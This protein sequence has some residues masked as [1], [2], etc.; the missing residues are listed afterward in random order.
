MLASASYAT[1]KGLNRPFARPTAQSRRMGHKLSMGLTPA[2]VAR[3]EG[4]PAAEVESLLTDPDFASLAEG[5]RALHAMSEEEQ[6]RILTQLARHLLMEATALGDVRVATY[7]LLQ[8]RMGK[9]PART[10]A[11]GVIAAAKREPRPAPL[12]ALRTASASP[13]PAR[14]SDDPD[15]RAI[16]RVEDRLCGELAHEHAVVHAAVAADE[17]AADDAAEAAAESGADDPDPED[18]PVEPLQDKAGHRTRRRSRP[19]PSTLPS[20]EQARA[21]AD[22]LLLKN[23]APDEPPTPRAGAP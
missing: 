10:L 15:L 13:R 4:L 5:Y 22:L 8:E 11:D 21:I 19:C 2:Q 16:Q 18:A 3:L 17:P 14:P 1:R 23:A 7:I 20:Y 12:P 6:R 9:D